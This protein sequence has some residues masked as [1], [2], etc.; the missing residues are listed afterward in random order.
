[1]ARKLEGFKLTEDSVFYDGKY[2]C[3]YIEVIAFIRDIEN[4]NWKRRV[5]FK[6]TFGDFHVLDIGMEQFR[7]TSDFWKILGKAGFEVLDLKNEKLVLKYLKSNAPNQRITCVTKTGWITDT[8]FI[9]PS[10]Y[11][12][13]DETNEHF[14]LDSKVRNVGFKIKGEIKEWQNN[15][16]K[17]C[18]GNDILTLAICVAFSGTLLRFTNQSCSAAH[19]VGKSSIGKTSALAVAASIWGD[20]RQFIMQWR[21]TSNAIETWAESHNEC[22]LILDELSQISARDAG[23]MIY[24]LGNAKG[25]ARLNSEAEQREIKQ[26]QIS[27]LSSGEIG[28]ADKISENNEKAKAGQLVRFIDFHTRYRRRPKSSKKLHI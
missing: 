24:T 15:I 5:R 27:I 9:C 11:A 20:S 28:I 14:S 7:N 17:Y 25:K 23:N 2:L 13:K 26:W 18:E 3:R 10:F 22:L 12:A 6:N 19:L 1:M 4:E 16:C 8:Q 21:V